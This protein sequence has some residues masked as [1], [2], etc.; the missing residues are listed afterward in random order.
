MAYVSSNTLVFVLS[1]PLFG[2]LNMHGLLQYESDSGP[3]NYLVLLLE[4]RL[5]LKMR[6]EYPTNLFL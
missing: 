3:I 5:F 6:D 4:L 1:V 2:L